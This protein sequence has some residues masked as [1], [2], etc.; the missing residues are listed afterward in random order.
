MKHCFSTARK[1]FEWI[2]SSLSNIQ[3]FKI[4]HGTLYHWTGRLRILSRHASP[5]QE[6]IPQIL[7]Y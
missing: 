6:L 2:Y 5:D 1:L 3:I 4:L 7:Q